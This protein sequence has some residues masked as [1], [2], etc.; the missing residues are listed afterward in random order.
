MN[1]YEE[2]MKL[3]SLIFFKAKSDWIIIYKLKEF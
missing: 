3:K 2:S 1:L